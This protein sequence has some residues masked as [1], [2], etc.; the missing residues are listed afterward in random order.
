[1]SLR[2]LHADCSDA[3]TLTGLTDC[4]LQEMS[5]QLAVF[6]VSK[7]GANLCAALPQQYLKLLRSTLRVHHGIWA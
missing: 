4:D 2:N 1:M 5:S 3:E 7:I 6:N